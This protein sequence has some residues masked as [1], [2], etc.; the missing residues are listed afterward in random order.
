MRQQ[1]R[2]KNG[3]PCNVDETRGGQKGQQAEHV[4]LVRTLKA[5]VWQ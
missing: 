5:A 1:Q 2:S 4:A 3:S